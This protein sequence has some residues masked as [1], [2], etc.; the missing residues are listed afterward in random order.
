MGTY[1]VYYEDH[2]GEV[3][4]IEMEAVNEE[5]AKEE[6]ET[7]WFE[8]LYAVLYAIPVPTE[9]DDHD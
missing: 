4:V 9:E 8:D 3:C 2:H 1:L 7:S 6:V 5:E